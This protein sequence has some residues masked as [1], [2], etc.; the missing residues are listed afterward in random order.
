LHSIERESRSTLQWRSKIESGN[1]GTQPPGASVPILY[2]RSLGTQRSECLTEW[3]VHRCRH[4][5]NVVR[6]WL[7][8][9]THEPWLDQNWTELPNN[10]WVAATDNG[11]VSQDESFDQLIVVLKSLDIPIDNVSFAFATFGLWQ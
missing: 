6:V 9:T 1:S 4:F 5:G 11:I 8:F 10:N 7:R 2:K 3:R